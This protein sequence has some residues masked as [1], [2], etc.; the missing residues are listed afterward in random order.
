[1]LRRLQIL[2]GTPIISNTVFEKNT[3][4]E[5]EMSLLGD[6][7][8]EHLN[9]DATHEPAPPAI[10]ISSHSMDIGIDQEVSC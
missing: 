2:K 9:D 7:F 4:M 3:N 8:F 6:D 1:M 10:Q 5:L